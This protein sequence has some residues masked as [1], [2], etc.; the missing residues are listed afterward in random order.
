MQT[1]KL[2]IIIE[3]DTDGFT[4]TVP[5]LPGCFSCGDTEQDAFE[6]IQEAIALY[7]EEPI[8]EPT[9]APASAELNQQPS[10]NIIMRKLE[11]N[12]A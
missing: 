6:N 5:Q 1:I 2:T 3:Q 11:L 10:R 12:V 8:L 7:F 4:A 9:V